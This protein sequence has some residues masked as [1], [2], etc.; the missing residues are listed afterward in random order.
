ME[1]III[2]PHIGL[3]DQLIMS[4]YIHYMFT[5]K[6]VN[7][8]YL[9][10]RNIHTSTLEHLYEDYIR[11]NKLSFICIDNTSSIHF[12]KNKQFGSD[13]MY[14]NI[15][16]KIHSFGLESNNVS[17]LHSYFWAD[18]FYIQAGC[19][20]LIRNTFFK[21]P[22][23]LKD[24]EYNYKL[25][26]KLINNSEYVVI[27]DDPSRGLSLNYTKVKEVLLNNKTSDLPVIYLG[28]NRYKYSLIDGLNNIVL[29]SSS[30]YND[31][32]MYADGN[33]ST[34]EYRTGDTLYAQNSLFNS[35]HILKN[36][37]EAHFMDTSTA[38]M[39]SYITDKTGTFYLH[40]YLRPHSEKLYG[41]PWIIINE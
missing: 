8:I 37:K 25:V 20:P 23:N 17:F 3:G 21:F 30:V 5:R 29:E 1:N 18:S 6:N 35:Y 38:I 40:N 15:P 22:S 13:V 14:N 33:S 39:A 10:T 19:D 41:K 32:F 36:C 31:G 7:L 12:L 9:V 16:F 2:F 26:M 11:S 24:S 4:G 28:I 27:Q 34:V